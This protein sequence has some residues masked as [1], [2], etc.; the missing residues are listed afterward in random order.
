[1]ND[2]ILMGGTFRKTS[3]KTAAVVTHSHSQISDR[4][5]TLTFEFSTKPL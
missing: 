5:V 3:H 2:K 4:N 1:M